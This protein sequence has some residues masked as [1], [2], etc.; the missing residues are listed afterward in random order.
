MQF[1]VIGNPISHSLSPLLHNNA[2]KALKIPAYYGRI[3]F[4]DEEHFR[5]HLNSY[6]LNGANITIPFKEVAY[7]IC[8]SVFGIAKKIGATNTL[9]F[10]EDKIYGYNTDAL[11]F[12]QCIEKEN[13]KTALV[14]G[15]GGS[16]RAIVAI[17]EEKGFEV[18]LINRSKQRLQNFQD[19][20]IQTST[21][22]DFKP[23][24]SF[25]IIIN[26]TPSTLTSHTLPLEENR[27]IDIF[28]NAKM[29]FDL[30]Y[31]IDSPFLNLAKTHHL[32]TED[33]KNMLIYQ[34]ILAF[35]IFMQSFNKTIDTKILKTTMQ[36]T[37]Y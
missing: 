26:T 6:A 13:F 2:F 4:N 25:D 5:T 16:A 17:L 9:V 29:A 14:I 19:F 23:K 37:L 31:G 21:F 18:T 20:K 34:A 28:Q 7:S 27:L 12:Y 1:A 33:G 3:L 8:D 36:T 35:E 22:E 10:K 11:G 15:A 30:V 32:K 24:H